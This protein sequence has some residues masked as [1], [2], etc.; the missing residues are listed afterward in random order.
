MLSRNT[1]A[2]HF[3]QRDAAQRA[4]TALV[5]AGFEASV[6]PAADQIVVRVDAAGREAEAARILTSAG[7]QLGAD[8]ALARDDDVSRDTATGS[9]GQDRAHDLIYGANNDHGGTWGGDDDARAADFDTRSATR[10]GT[11]DPDPG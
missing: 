10:P 8:E 6:A 1:V 9:V 7:G 3:D 2:A 11:R 4:R 5:S